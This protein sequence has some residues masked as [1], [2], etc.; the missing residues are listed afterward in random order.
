MF[1]K[2][3]EVRLLKGKRGA[4]SRVDLNRQLLLDLWTRGPVVEMA[5]QNREAAIHRGVPP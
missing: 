5:Y 3:T 2:E 1:V 4:E